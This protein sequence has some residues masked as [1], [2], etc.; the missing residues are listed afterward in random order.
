MCLPCKRD[1]APNTSAGVGTAD[2]GPRWCTSRHGQAAHERACELAGT[3]NA[4]PGNTEDDPC[5]AGWRVDATGAHTYNGARGRL[6]TTC[7]LCALIGVICRTCQT[8]LGRRRNAPRVGPAPAMA[9]GACR[10]APMATRS[11]APYAQQWLGSG[12]SRPVSPSVPHDARLGPGACRRSDHDDTRSWR[13]ERAS[14]ASPTPAA[15]ITVAQRASAPG[16]RPGSCVAATFIPLPAH[17]SSGGRGRGRSPRGRRASSDG[18]GGGTCPPG[19]RP[20]TERDD[21]APCCPWRRRCRPTSVLWAHWC[22]KRGHGPTL[23]RP[24]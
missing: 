17:R 23:S 22:G 6:A 7:R 8:I 13:Y 5:T 19:I 20:R 12:V 2:A 4:P 18:T 21:R 15:R 24:S 16:H 10:T 11:P 1:S 14:P 3:T 9:T